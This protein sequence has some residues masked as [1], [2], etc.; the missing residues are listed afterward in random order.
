MYSS[1][2]GIQNIVLSVY[3]DKRTVFRLK[4][5]SLLVGETNFQS[6]NKKLNYYVRT[7]K[8]LNPR[9]GIYAKPDYN[10]EELACIIYTPSYISLDY[11]LHKSGVIFQYDSRITAIS[12]LNRSIEVNDRTFQFRKIKGEILVN[13]SGI[14]R[15]EDI[16]IASAERAF[17]DLMYLSPEYYFDNLRPLNRQTVNKLLSIFHSKSLSD[18]VKKILQHG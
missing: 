3:S 16:N 1:Q 6:L 10:P 18:R 17:L 12:Y 9:R 8:L 2:N 11:V 7:G 14:N 13:I 4:D 15:Q 5:I